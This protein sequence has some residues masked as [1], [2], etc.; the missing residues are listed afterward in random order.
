MNMKFIEPEC[1]YVGYKGKEPVFLSPY[2]LN[3]EQKAQR[4]GLSI[5]AFPKGHKA[6]GSCLELWREHLSD[7]EP[8]PENSTGEVS[9]ERAKQIFDQSQNIQKEFGSFP[10]YWA[11]YRASASGRGRIKSKI[12]NYV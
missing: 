8:S 3:A 9:E 4:E 2:K 1:F 5:L 7:F 11:W 10:V 6:Y 12:N